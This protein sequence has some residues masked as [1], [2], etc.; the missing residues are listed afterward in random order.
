MPRSFFHLLLVSVWSASVFFDPPGEPWASRRVV[1]G[2]V[3]GAPKP[4]VGALVAAVSAA[5]LRASRLFQRAARC[6]C[7]MWDK[8]QI[9]PVAPVG[10]SAAFGY[11]FEN[12]VSDISVICYLR[13]Q[14]AGRNRLLSPFQALHAV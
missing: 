1:G 10:F 12:D 7:G 14:A 11:L 4:E 5:A 9:R 8:G 2:A 3:E 6:F 13:S